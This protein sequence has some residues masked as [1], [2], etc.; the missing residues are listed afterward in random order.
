MGH[1][2]ERDVIVS[3][4]EDKTVKVWDPESGDCVRTLEGH[5]DKVTSVA[6]GHFGGRDVIVSGSEDKTV[7]MWDLESGDCVKTLNRRNAP[8]VVLKILKSPLRK[9]YQYR[10]F[11]V[12]TESNNVNLFEKVGA[13]SLF[14]ASYQGQTKVATML[15][16]KGA[17]KDKADNDGYTP[18]FVA[19]L[20]GHTEVATMLVAN[21]AD[22]DKAANDGVTPLY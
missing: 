18:L 8:V 17:D 12:E 22:K 2:R 1:F 6:M 14:M 9:V 11:K 13:S 19:S 21:G 5:Y 3:G 16:A 7:K 15:V 10:R 20:N 4:S